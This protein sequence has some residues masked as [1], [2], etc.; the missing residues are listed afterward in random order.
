[1]KKSFELVSVS[2]APQ[3]AAVR[4][5]QVADALVARIEVRDLFNDTYFYLEVGLETEE[6]AEATLRQK[7]E[8]CQTMEEL[9]GGF[10]QQLR[11]LGVYCNDAN[12]LPEAYFV[13]T[14]VAQALNLPRTKLESIEYF[15]LPSDCEDIDMLDSFHVYYYQGKCGVVT[16]DGVVTPP[17]FEEIWPNDEFLLGVLEGN[18]YFVVPDDQLIDFYGDE[19]EAAIR[20]SLPDNEYQ[21]WIDGKIY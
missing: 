4:N 3:V 19:P 8:S 11:E 13:E 17:V 12:R 9:V 18:E 1:M 2:K 20:V 15:D 16:K 7:V 14:R 10:N 21:D 5:G 6:N